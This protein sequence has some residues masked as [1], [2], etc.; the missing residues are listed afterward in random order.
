MQYLVEIYSCRS[1]RFRLLDGSFDDDCGR[2]DGGYGQNSCNQEGSLFHR[3]YRRPDL[4]AKSIMKSAVPSIPSLLESM[5]RSYV[6]ATP[7][8]PKV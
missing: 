3:C 8:L 7:Q 4:F 2:R 5:Q 1:K 6:D